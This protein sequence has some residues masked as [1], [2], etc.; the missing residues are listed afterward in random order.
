PAVVVVTSREGEPRLPYAHQFVTARAGRS[1]HRTPG[2][3]SGSA[4][5]QPAVP[6]VRPA[7]GG[8]TA[9]DDVVPALVH[10]VGAEQ[11]HPGAGV[12]LDSDPHGPRLCEPGLTGLGHPRQPLL[13]G[14]LAVVKLDAI[15]PVMP[16]GTVVGALLVATLAQVDRPAP[17]VL[18]A[19][20]WQG[21]CEPLVPD[22]VVRAVEADEVAG[23]RAHR[24]E[25]RPRGLDLCVRWLVDVPHQLGRS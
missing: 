7:L 2:K 24:M 15:E 22:M 17:E 19:D 5:E 1:V 18:C 11:Q 23:E 3:R 8:G 21:P 6:G 25:V 12:R 14:D 20:V 13:D 10:Q 16:H 4:P 9:E